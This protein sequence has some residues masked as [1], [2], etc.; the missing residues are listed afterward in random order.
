MQKYRYLTTGFWLICMFLVSCRMAEKPLAELASEPFSGLAF[1]SERDGNAEIYRVRASGADLMRLTDTPALDEDPNWSPD[2]RQIA[3]RSR[4]DGSS[5]IFVMQADGAEPRN[6]AQDP[7][8]SVNDEFRPVWHP[9]EPTL[10]IYTDRY[11][12]ITCAVHQL[13][14][15]PLA[16]EIENIRLIELPAANQIS[17]DWSPDGQTL[18]FSAAPCQSND[19]RLYLWKTATGEVSALTDAT[20]SPALYPAWASDGTRLAFASSASGEYDIYLLE[21]SSGAMANLTQNPA[22]DTQP[23]W[24]P[25]NAQIAF[26]SN[27]DGNDEI[28]IMDADGANARNLTQN[29]ARDYDPDWSAASGE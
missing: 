6:L 15:L 18:A 12:G 22:R 1:V 7:P 8:D 4:R 16:G 14:T 17:F 11:A 5:D 25:D 21:L 2:G 29:P 19:T 24:S 20:L 3:F 26:V 13:A 23:T 27:R 9:K 10:A 28:Y